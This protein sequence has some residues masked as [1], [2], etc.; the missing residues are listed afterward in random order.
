MVTLRTK[1]TFRAITVYV[2][3]DLDMFQL[4]HKQIPE[5]VNTIKHYRYE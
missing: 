4:K 2:G 1:D 5:Y 3:N